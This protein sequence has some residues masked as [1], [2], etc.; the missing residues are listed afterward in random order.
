MKNFLKKLPKFSKALA[1]IAIILLIWS[2]FIFAKG[3]PD[4]DISNA[5]CIDEDTQLDS[6][7]T[8]TVCI[9]GK[10]TI[11]TP[12]A[13]YMTGVSADGYILI[14]K[15]E[16]YQYYVSGD[17]VE[18]DFFDTQKQNISG[19]NNETYANEVFPTDFQNAVIVG[20]VS[21]GNVKLGE[22]YLYTLSGDYEYFSD[23]VCTSPVSDL[24]ES[25]YE[26]LFIYDGSQYYYSGDAENP[27][28]GDL[29]L[30]YEYVAP[31]ALG[32]VTA[33]GI[34]NGDTLGGT[35][36]N[37][38]KACMT[39][40]TVS[41]EEMAEMYSGSTKSLA[42]TLLV[43]AVICI[44]I[45]LIT[46]LIK[47][48]KVKPEQIKT[49]VCL[50]L[51]LSVMALPVVSAKA[52]FGD[53]G[54]GN[55]Y[56]GGGG[57]DSGD[58]DYGDD[59]DDYD[60]KTTTTESY[61]NYIGYPEGYLNDEGNAAYAVINNDGEVLDVNMLTSGTNEASEDSGLFM[62]V[63]IVIIIGTIVSSFKGKKKKRT[64]LP[65]GAA[66]TDASTLIQMSDY[67]Q[68]DPDF[69]AAALETKLSDMYVHFQHSW[70]NKDM[71]DLR[72][73]LTDEFYAQCES[74]LDN[75]T[76]NSQTNI[77]DNIVVE[78][79]VLKGWQQD[80]G[81]DIMI[82]EITACITDYVI[83][84]KSGEVVRGNKDVKKRMCY[85]WSIV[86]ATGT[87][88]GKAAEQS[89]CPNCGAPLSLNSASKC[90]YC[91]TIIT[92]AATDW[93]VSSIKGLSQRTLD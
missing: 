32:E 69:D 35:V 31:D 91:G 72:P 33:I 37:I 79:V 46:Y 90:E 48:K 47:S 81:N 70:Q 62:V 28:V 16:M 42:F 83:D 89:V 63:I 26:G 50:L 38:D 21:V 18:C 41:A 84:D 49:A 57:Y 65:A 36:G 82:A 20:D 80:G 13:D 52:D 10:P 14:R 87:V 93:A 53:Y 19:K 71:S 77:V 68:V 67:T 34:L 30:S 51:M 24:P 3:G 4:D 22:D 5:V 59:Y 78:S 54:G 12:P 92:T 23:S 6:H 11:N 7:D 15:V 8:E 40:K 1:A 76:R 39:D 55:D 25:L 17:E 45:V 29:R 43:L 88:S 73:Y 2:G 86:R 74:Q 60:D 66:R 61:Y 85:E 44:A 9:S 64:N 75:Y 27:V 58:Y 56:G